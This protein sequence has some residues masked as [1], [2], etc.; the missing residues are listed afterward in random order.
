MT[1]IN[2]SA[3]AQI[4]PARP[5]RFAMVV[6]TLVIGA[7]VPIAIFK[8]L[9]ALGLTPVWALAAGSV[10]VLLNNLRL[11]IKARRL[12][13]IGI[14]AVAGVGGGAVGSLITG[15]LGS[16]IIADCVLSSAWGLVFAVS[17][18][19]SRPVMFFVIRQFAA[20]GDASRIETWNELWRYGSFRLGLRSITAVCGASFFVGILIELLLVRVLSL[21]AAVTVGPLISL[22]VTGLLIVLVRLG[23][24]MTRQRLERVEHVTWP[25]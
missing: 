24:R 10:P 5:F 9:E 3:P 2:Q 11:W 6:P 12:E 18:L 22:G 15:S 20:G 8:T 21:D 25:L 14:M 19:T 13:P 23:M 16:R 4:A 1:A 17:L 7:V